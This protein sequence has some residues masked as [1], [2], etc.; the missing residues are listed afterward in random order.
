ME[1]LCFTINLLENILSFSARQ[2]LF[3]TYLSLLLTLCIHDW[4]SCSS[5]LLSFVCMYCCSHWECYGVLRCR[6]WRRPKRR[7]RPLERW[8][9]GAVLREVERLGAHPQ[10]VGIGARTARAGS[11]WH[12][13]PGELHEE[14]EGT[15]WLVMW[16]LLTAL[17][18]FQAFLVALVGNCDNNQSVSKLMTFCQCRSDNDCNRR[19]RKVYSW[20]VVTWWQPGS[21][22]TEYR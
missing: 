12:E 18:V 3:R 9:G 21:L 10:H 17:Q 2:W 4:C 19:N 15:V 13:A 20:C 11:E 1:S 5:F 16:H 14:R 8:V 7:F 22:A 6:E